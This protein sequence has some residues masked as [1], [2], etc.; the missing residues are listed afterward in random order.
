MQPMASLRFEQ[1]SVLPAIANSC[2]TIP[3]QV[4]EYWAEHVVRN[5]I[6]QT[7]KESEEYLEWRFR[8][9]PLFREFSGL[10]GN[11]NGEIVLDYGCGPG[12]DV[13]GFAVHSNASKIIGVDVSEK[14]LDLAA[15]RCSLHEIEPGR[16]ELILL[17]DGNPIIPLDDHSVD[18]INCQGVLHH[19]THPTVILKEFYRVMKPTS[20][21]V[22]MVYNADSIWLHLYTAYEKLVLEN[23]FPGLNAYE[24]FSKNVD[25]IGC[26]I[27]RCYT[28]QEFSALCES[29]GFNTEYMGGYFSDTEMSSLQKYLN[30]AL[31]DER[32]GDVHKQFLKH[33]SCDDSGFPRYQGKC[34]GIG[35]VYRLYCWN[36]AD[37]TQRPQAQLS[38]ARAELMDARH[39][40]SRLARRLSELD[41]QWEAI[42]PEFQALQ[43]WR[44]KILRIPGMNVLRNVYRVLRRL[45]TSLQMHKD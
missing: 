4:D 7:A 21:A 27:A 11:H 42:E 41:R 3:T 45:R 20:R 37:A 15:R 40:V 12:N 31:D 9:Y 19:S 32:V 28:N 38:V 23:A 16:V 29:I 13:V 25:G 6:F 35:G 18:F 22:V 1:K 17:G 5:K 30:G 43:E 36:K 44:A 8:S 33:L 26:P 2:R 39:Q 34:A 14:A 10:Y 24:A